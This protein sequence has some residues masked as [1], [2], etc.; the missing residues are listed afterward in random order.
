MCSIY[1]HIQKIHGYIKDE[2][3]LRYN[4]CTLFAVLTVAPAWRSFLTTLE[5]PLKDAIIRA[6]APPLSCEEAWRECLITVHGDKS[7]TENNT[8]SVVT[9]QKLVYFNW[10]ISVLCTKTEH[11]LFLLCIST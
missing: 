2:S 3:P 4:Y 9:K 6:V 5:W 11:T 10:R 7:Y 8:S 1:L